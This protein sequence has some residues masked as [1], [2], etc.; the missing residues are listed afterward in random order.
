MNGILAKKLGMTQVFTEQ[1]ESVPV[2][3][4]EAGP[5]VVVS[6]KTIDKEGYKA[7]QVGFG[8]KKESR[9][10]KAEMGHFNKA[11][12]SPREHLAEFDVVDLDAWP[13]GK[14]FGAADFAD[15]KQVNV[16]GISKG[17]GFAGTIKRHNFH[18]GP[19]SHGTHNMREPGSISANSYPGRVFPG[20]KMAGQY[21]NKKVT[22]K[23]LQVIK[24]DGEK[25]LIFVRGAVPGPKNGVIVVRKD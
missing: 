1:G 11:G 18:S 7:V 25:N 3:V 22:V 13:V 4:L 12:V 20:K 14:E 6:H 24:V 5:C 10:N 19:R 16:S 9:S 8:L 17:R 21:G 15:V 2:T 23:H